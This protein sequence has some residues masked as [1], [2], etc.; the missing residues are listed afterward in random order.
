M[1]LQCS[2]VRGAL[3][4]NSG[5]LHCKAKVLSLTPVIACLLLSLLSHPQHFKFICVKFCRDVHI[6]EVLNSAR[7]PP[8]TPPPTKPIEDGGSSSRVSAEVQD[9]DILL[10][11]RLSWYATPP[12]NSGTGSS[13]LQLCQLHGLL[14]ARSAKSGFQAPLQSFI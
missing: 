6:V 7:S 2:E 5:W 11:A 3:E 4:S 12:E 8:P 10:L 9:S 1:P 13:S 14:R